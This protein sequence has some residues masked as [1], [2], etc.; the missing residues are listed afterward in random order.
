MEKVRHFG[1][2]ETSIWN[3]AVARGIQEVSRGVREGTS[4]RLVFLQETADGQFTVAQRGGLEDR[5]GWSLEF[6]SIRIS[7]WSLK[8]VSFSRHC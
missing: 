2:K 3:E 6:V 1:V 7:R 4:K 5:V 8:G